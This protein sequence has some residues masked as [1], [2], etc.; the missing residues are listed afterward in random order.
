MDA[1]TLAAL[2]L[3]IRQLAKRYHAKIEAFRVKVRR[4]SG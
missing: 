3:E 1:T 2:E 4:R